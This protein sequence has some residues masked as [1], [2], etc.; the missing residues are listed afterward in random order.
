MI[1]ILLFEVL[2]IIL[3][4]AI[5]LLWLLHA[6]RVAARAGAAQPSFGEAPWIWL[7]AMGVAL[8]V[9]LLAGVT[10]IGSGEDRDGVYVGPQARPDGTVAPGHMEPRR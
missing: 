5:Y 8:A 7:A 9:L 10:L 6:R 3:P 1:R 2:P 4:S